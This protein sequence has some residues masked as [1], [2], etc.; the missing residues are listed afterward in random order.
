M[1]IASLWTVWGGDV[2]PAEKDPTGGTKDSLSR[3]LLRD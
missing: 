2:F 1:T 3:A